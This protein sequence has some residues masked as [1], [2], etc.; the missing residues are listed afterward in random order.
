VR[1][2]HQVNDNVAFAAALR[3][4]DDRLVEFIQLGRNHPRVGQFNP[5]FDALDVVGE[6]VSVLVLELN[7]DFHL[8]AKREAE[9]LVDV[10]GSHV[11]DVGDEHVEHHDLVRESLVF[12]DDDCDLAVLVESLDAL[13]VDQLDNGGLGVSVLV[14]VG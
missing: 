12:F 2:L 7:W 11:V 6:R 10:F 3:P 9:C 14:G 4:H 8:G 13:V 5:H 1:V